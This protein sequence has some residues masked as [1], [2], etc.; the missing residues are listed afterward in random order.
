M[1]MNPTLKLGYKAFISGWAV[2]TGCQVL[3]KD[4]LGLDGYLQWTLSS[5]VDPMITVP[6][7]IFL[8]VWGYIWFRDIRRESKAAEGDA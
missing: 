1:K 6:F 5:W 2:T 7:S 4:L 3:Q 8:I